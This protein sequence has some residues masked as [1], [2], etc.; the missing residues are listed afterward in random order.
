MHETNT[1]AVWDPLVR[2]FHWSLVGAFVL[3]WLSEDTLALHTTVGYAVF[4]LVAVRIVWGSLGPRYA[5][6]SDFVHGPATVAGY[7]RAVL[8]LDPPYYVGHNPAGGWMVV[9]LLAVLLL[10][11]FSGVAA[12]GAEEH[13]GPLAAWAS[14]KAWEDAH[15]AL[16][17]LSL[18]LVAIHIL[19]VL[20]ESLLHGENLPRAML[21][22]RK[23]ARPDTSS[24]VE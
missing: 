24:A 5:R 9:V 17:N 21:T 2:A 23:K 18:A 4:G 12:Y 19:G 11:A 10:T 8:R 20:V 3:A 13:G 22:G 1:V 16:A 6:F 14:S 15:E 7:L